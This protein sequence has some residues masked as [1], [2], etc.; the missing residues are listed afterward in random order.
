[1]KYILFSV[2]F[3]TILTSTSFSEIRNYDLVIENRVFNFTGEDVVAMSI[4]GSVPGPVLRFK[5]GETARINVTNKMSVSTSIHWH[6]LLLPNREDG[7]PYLTTPPIKP[8]TTYTYEFPLKQAGTYWYHSHTGLQEQL[9]VYGSIVIEPEQERTDIEL[10][11]DEI[12]VVLSD[13]TNEDPHE[14]LRSLKR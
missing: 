5:E 12:V 6:G 14:V 11:E 9:G 7:V 4:N 3:L 10:P 13:W 8:G 1:M 2:L